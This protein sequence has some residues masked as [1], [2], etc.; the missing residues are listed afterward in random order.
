MYLYCMVKFKTLFC[1]KQVILHCA[2]SKLDYFIT[3]F[4]IDK[5][6]FGFLFKICSAMCENNTSQIL[7]TPSGIRC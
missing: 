3:Q 2:K 7:M 6:V 4:L 5:N 1:V